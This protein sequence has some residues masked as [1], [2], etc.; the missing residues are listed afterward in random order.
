MVP[1]MDSVVEANLARL[2][3]PSVTSVS[4]ASLADV[5]LTIFSGSDD[6]ARA[7]GIVAE[8]EVMVVVSDP[9]V[10]LGS[11][12]V[13]SRGCNNTLFFDNH[14]LAERPWGGEFAAN[15]RFA[16][17]DSIVVINRLGGQYVA[18]QDVFLRSDRQFLFWGEGSSAVGCSIEMEGE[19]RGAVIGDDALISSGV[20]LRNYDM[21][22]IHDLETGACISHPPVDMVLERH[23][24]LGQDA[25]LLNCQKVGRG[26][27][28]GARALLKTDLPPRVVAAGVPAR[29]IRHGVSW[30]RASTG[31]SAA[32]RRSLGLSDSA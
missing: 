16:A 22:A 25:L 6:A 19:E 7:L 1:G 14:P 29:V 26:S 12:R 21:H 20:W 30:G 27:I 5:P 15:I 3:Q 23:V 17:N 24:W 28:V 32:E 18:L 8:G 2:L 10:K 11:V 9:E 4:P 13:Q 31:M